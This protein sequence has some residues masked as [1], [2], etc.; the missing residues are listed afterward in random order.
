MGI[1]V[2]ETN[3]V[4]SIAGRLATDHERN[5][6][7]RFNADA[8]GI[9]DDLFLCCHSRG[10]TRS[11][12][13]DPGGR[14]FD[15]P[16]S[17]RD[18]LLVVKERDVHADLPGEVLPCEDTL[19]SESLI[20]RPSVLHTECDDPSPLFVS[21]RGQDLQSRFLEDFDEMSG[22]RSNVLPDLVDAERGDD[23]QSGQCGDLTSAIMHAALQSARIIVQIHAVDIEPFRLARAH[24]ADQRR[25]SDLEEILAH[26]EETGSE[27][28]PQ[29][30]EGRAGEEI[31]VGLSDVDGNHARRLRGIDDEIGTMRVGDV[32][33]TSQVVA[34]A[35]PHGH[36]ADVDGSGVG[37]HQSA[38][39]AL[40]YPTVAS[41]S[42]AHLD[43]RTHH[44]GVDIAL[45]RQFI[46]HDVAAWG[47]SD[48][49]RRDA[50]PHTGVLDGG[51]LAEV[52]ADECRKEVLAIVKT[53]NEI[54]TGVPLPPPELNKLLNR[55]R[56]AVGA[57]ADIGGAQVHRVVGDVE[58]IANRTAFIDHTGRKFKLPDSSI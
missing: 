44:P 5:A 57:G 38:E 29:P 39:L 14:D 13:P 8:V 3:D 22:K 21:G 20:E 4:G 7:A 10:Q 18:I 9:S 48:E 40:G 58:L 45:V 36:V 26:I 1:A 33:Q 41:P 25:H 49:T 37:I 17:S 30:F 32:R 19:R 15:G 53:L 47:W 56:D 12:S 35:M 51:Y 28:A 2:N 46:H 42:I 11:R 34:K 55:R 16:E 24:P 43:S 52:C 6:S 31:D 23:A 54:P 50:E 27:R